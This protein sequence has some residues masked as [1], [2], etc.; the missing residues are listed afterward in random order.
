MSGS[1]DGSSRASP[2]QLKPRPA[3]H[4]S[5]LT[6][7]SEPP[8]F[9]LGPLLSSRRHEA[10]LGSRV[11]SW[12][13][14][15]VPRHVCMA[16]QQNLLGVGEGRAG[17]SQ[18]HQSDCIEAPGAL[19]QHSLFKAAHSS[20]AQTHHQAT[21]NGDDHLQKAKWFRNRVSYRSKRR[22][23]CISCFSSITSSQEFRYT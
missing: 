20:Q 3:P 21:I 23:A 10:P 6:S 19:T 15:A 5:T 12:S 18:P 9:C 2:A 14:R 7:R 16:L 13:K 1:L 11:T 8:G 17:F 22:C 4:Q